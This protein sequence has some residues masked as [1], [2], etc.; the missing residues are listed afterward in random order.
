M[1][2]TEF[3][4]ARM[5]GAM[6]LGAVGCVSL[7]MPAVYYSG[8]NRRALCRHRRIPIC[9]RLICNGLYFVRPLPIVGDVHAAGDVIVGSR[10][11]VVSP[12][13]R[14]IFG[15]EPHPN[16]GCSLLRELLLMG[17]ILGGQATAGERE[18]E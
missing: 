16:F 10:R 7:H 5:V 18:S 3:A 13:R 2:C 9:L 6:L 11:C 17:A 15:I 12:A 14:V 8:T 1:P 4:S